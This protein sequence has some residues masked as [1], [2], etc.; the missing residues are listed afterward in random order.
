[1]DE[2]DYAVDPVELGLYYVDDRLMVRD[3]HVE[4]VQQAFAAGTFVVEPEH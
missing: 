3:E 2:T 1:M 4:T